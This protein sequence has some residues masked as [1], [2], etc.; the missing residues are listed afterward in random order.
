VEKKTEFCDPE[1]KKNRKTYMRKINERV[2]IKG[3]F[4]FLSFSFFIFFYHQLLLVLP[5]QNRFL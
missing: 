5:I 3:F 2:K 1:N 4:F